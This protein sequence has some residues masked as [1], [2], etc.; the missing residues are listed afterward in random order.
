MSGEETGAGG[1]WRESKGLGMA[2]LAGMVLLI[3]FDLLFLP[4][5]RA[6]SLK[7]ADVY[8]Q[9]AGWRSFGFSELAGGNFPL[10]TPL[11]YG[12]MP[13][14]GGFQSA[15]LYPPNW[16]FMVLPLAKAINW[17][18][19][20][21][22]WWI[23]CG[24]YVWLRYWGVRQAAAV[25]GGACMMLAAPF[26]LHIYAGHLT[27]LCVMAWVPWL[28]W[29]LLRWEEARTLRWIVA[30]AA[31]VAVQILAGHPQYVYYTG[32]VV[33]LYAL[34][35]T[36]FVVKE[37]R[38]TFLAGFVVMYVLG[39]MLSAAQLLP[40]I[41]ASGESIRSGGTGKEF[42]GSYS[43]PPANLFTL[44]VPG[45][46]GDIQGLRY[47]G[48][49]LY[50]EMSAFGGVIALSCAMIGILSGPERKRDRLVLGG[51]ALI[52]V[53]LALGKYTPLFDVLFHG[54]PGFSLF[55]GS[56]KFIFFSA[57][58]LSVLAGLGANRL[59]V[60]PSLWRNRKLLIAGGA[61]VV[62]LFGLGALVGASDGKRG[63]WGGIREAQWEGQDAT[64]IVETDYFSDEL[65]AA[66]AA[67]ASTGL[68]IAGGTVLV[69]L[70]LVLAI[71][72]RREMAYLLLFVGVVELLVFAGR[73]RVSFSLSDLN[74]QVQADAVGENPEQ[75]RGL[76][77]T[78]TN[79]GMLTGIPDIWGDDP[80]VL[81]RYAEFM[82]MT[83]GQA[84]DEASQQLI[85]QKP[86]PLWSMLRT[87]Y[88][89]QLNPQGGMLL[90]TFGVE[91][92]RRFELISN[93]TVV[94]ERDALLTALAEGSFDPK[95]M[96]Y[97]E[98][99][100]EIGEASQGGAMAGDWRIETEDTD[101]VV[102]TVETGAPM[103]LLMTDP[104][105]HGWRVENL[106]KGTQGQDY[107]LMPA[108]YVLSAIP[109]EAGTHR[110]RVY[111]RPR[112]LT[113]GILIS[114]FSVGGCVAGLIWTRR[115]TRA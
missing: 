78:G 41:E 29:C 63:F 36:A 19:A 37:K 86:S 72:K 40:G 43:F 60:D 8:R 100:P 25:F 39:A 12:G 70:L 65:A 55:R 32:L 4:G 75:F 94:P 71:S 31:V 84:P 13:Y 5:D 23:A 114:V 83:Q 53:V 3:F 24:V 9:F 10:W 111:Y 30:G 97:L 2:V 92:L 15:L 21:H 91:P 88:V 46:F 68:W 108:N 61:A 20:F 38:L 89:F 50:W 93:Y 18:V 56:S 96:V 80:G 103:I 112:T 74:L 51:L 47:W 1:G 33:S 6:L 79:R 104:Y 52:A 110:L 7:G 17:S 85:M 81:A 95:A 27:N 99:E 48:R 69:F 87:K 11:V 102:L 14:F 66:S 62:V 44:V 54:L 64:H 59:L 90:Q 22:V 101:E 82:A 49:W 26:F 57:M 58:A 98:E 45:L 73:H 106:S 67:Y 28:A 107:R 16:I 109:L 113:G 34:L 77:V 105:S 76:D 35:I 42:S 115:R